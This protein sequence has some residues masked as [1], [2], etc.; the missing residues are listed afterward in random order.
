MG[1][2]TAY[3]NGDH[4]RV[5]LGGGARV[6]VLWQPEKDTRPPHLE[7]RKPPVA[8][9]FAPDGQTLAVAAGSLIL[10]WDV[11]SG[12]KQATLRGHASE[13]TAL[14][15]TPDGRTLISGGKD[16]TVRSWDVRSGRERAV[17][18][19]PIGKVF[20]VAVAPDGMTAAAAGDASG[21]V[22]WDLEPF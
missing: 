11:A 5:D 15:W 1:R 4:R 9:A 22:L 12:E 7:H 20:A 13:V 21:I 17:Y 10:L 6:V 3:Y 18:Q 19:W 2:W 8:L 16:R 14:S